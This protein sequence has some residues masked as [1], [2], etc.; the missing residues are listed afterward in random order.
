MD[1]GRIR[2]RDANG[3][4]REYNLNQ[5]LVINEYNLQEE[6]RLQ[7]SKYVFWSSVLEQVRGYQESAQLQEERVRADLYE[8][9]RQSLIEGGSPKPTKDQIEAWI[10]RQEEYVKARE[11]V[12][13]YSNFVRQLQYVVKA[14]EQRRDMLT[15]VGADKRRAEEYERSLKM[16]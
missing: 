8:K 9:A 13:G 12:L 15:Q 7:P 4:V 14:F 16:M 6:F 3:E 1:F 11:Q 2:I 10:I 5:E